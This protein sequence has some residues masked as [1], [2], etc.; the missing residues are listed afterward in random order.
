MG[1]QPVAGKDSDTTMRRTF[2]IVAL[3]FLIWASVGSGAGAQGTVVVRVAPAVVTI[4]VNGTSDV[5]VEVVDVEGLYGF[6]LVLTFDPAVV[7]V[8][9][10]NS[11]RPGVQVSFG[12]F[13]DPGLSARDTADNAAGT[14]RYAMTQLNP[15]EPKDGTGN[16]IVVRLRGKVTGTSRLVLSSVTLVNRGA[17]EI[18]STAQDGQA[19]VIAAGGNLP[20]ATPIPTQ[21]PPS[22]V[23]TPGPIATATPTVPPPTI[24]NPPTVEPTATLMPPAATTVPQAVTTTPTAL[25]TRSVDPTLMDTATIVPNSSS[26][27]IETPAPSATAQEVAVSPG[28]TTPI[29][30]ALS[31][32]VTAPAAASA[33]L[34]P[35]T[36][37]LEGTLLGV[38]G[39]A[40]ALALVLAVIIG[41]ILLIRRRAQ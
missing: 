31:T 9:D 24:T 23:P 20:T 14:V 8:V 37:V 30:T 15:S 32:P 1:T 36:R 29:V 27:V 7:E 25:A 5:A 10:A 17:T 3:V 18:P 19:S 16:L 26:A 22:P 38:A 2:C 11:N 41:F 28:T 33:G 6:D 35:G 13:L 4:P 34:Q 39:G 12:T 40:L 21:A